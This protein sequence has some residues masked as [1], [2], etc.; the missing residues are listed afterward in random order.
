MGTNFCIGI[1]ELGGKVYSADIITESKAS[2]SFIGNK[3]KQEDNNIYQMNI[4]VTNEQSVISVVKEIIN[5][6]KKIDNLIFSVSAKAIDHYKS[7]T[8]TSLKGWQTVV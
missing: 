5:K 1:A 8:E 6:E 7:F 4:D 3:K 2:E